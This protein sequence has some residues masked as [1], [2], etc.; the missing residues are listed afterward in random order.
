MKYVLPKIALLLFILTCLF[1]PRLS[2]AAYV[3]DICN[4][5]EATCSRDAVGVFMKNISTTCG[6]TGKCTLGD[7]MIV[8]D[9][10]ADFIFEIIGSLLLAFYVYGGFMYLAS[11]GDS[12]LIEK[13]K[14]AIKT[15][16][17]GFLIIMFAYLG[18]NSLKA[19][20]TGG[21]PSAKPGEDFVDC[22]LEENDGKQCEAA[23][24]C[25]NKQCTFECIAKNPGYSCKSVKDPKS[26]NCI[27]TSGLCGTGEGY[28]CK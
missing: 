26:A 14:T 24:V 3:S 13:G 21:S 25:F 23:Q 22:S 5:T 4:A 8:V 16:T 1:L 10:V 27:Q 12:K 18:V 15:A 20:F 9:N 28:C 19:F 7:I 17:I 6:N 11:H 2:F